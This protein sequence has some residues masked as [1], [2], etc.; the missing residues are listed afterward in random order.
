MAH[1][2]GECAM[3][4]SLGYASGVNNSHTSA[5]KVKWRGV[6]DDKVEMEDIRLNLI[7]ALLLVEDEI[8]AEDIRLNVLCTNRSLP[9]NFPIILEEID[10]NNTSTA[11]KIKEISEKD[12]DHI[13][14]MVQEFSRTEKYTRDRS[15]IELSG[16]HDT[17]YDHPYY[18]DQLR[19][20]NLA[21]VNQ[22][23][24]FL[25]EDGP[26]NDEDIPKLR[27]RWLH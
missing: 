25:T 5:P 6:R 27:A 23:F 1:A 17:E 13:V 9:H 20:A 24:S 22:D 16:H 26:F 10:A 7:R 3:A 2:S 4:H 18:E 21:N 8:D 19:A 14:E 12:M 15:K 11:P